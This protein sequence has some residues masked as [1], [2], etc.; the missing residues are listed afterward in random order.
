VSQLGLQMAP[1]GQTK[2]GRFGAIVAVLLAFVVVAVLLAGLLIFGLRLIGSGNANDYSGDGTGQVDVRVAPDATT[3]QIA[4]TLQADGVIRS[5]STFLA[6]TANDD[7]VRRIQPGTYRMR[8]HMSSSAALDVLLDPTARVTARVVIPEG[9]PTKQVLALLASKGGLNQAQLAAAAAKTG[10]LG[11]PPYANDQLEGFL[12]PATYNV[13]PSTTPREQLRVMVARWRQ[14]A[15][16]VDLVSAA[17]AQH[18]TPYQALIIA[19]LVQAE[20]KPKDFAKVARVIDNRIAAG[21]PLQLDTTVLYG[22]GRAGGPVSTADTKVDTPYN[23]YLHKGLPP[24]PIDNPG[25]AALHAVLH[26]ATGDWLYYVTVNP[27]TGETKF[28]NSYQKFLQYK[29]EYKSNS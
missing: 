18:L 27:T 11:L 4:Q 15:S 21:M 17:K 20:V 14:A 13:D 10:T 12:F 28:T 6:I 22:L 9:T 7:R 19:S 23:T 16:D 24:T 1:E 5:A 8:E 25:E 29:Q 3:E 2:R 26:P